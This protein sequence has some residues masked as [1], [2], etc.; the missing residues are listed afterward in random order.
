MAQPDG[1]R[2]ADRVAVARDMCRAG[3]GSRRIGRR[4]RPL[5]LQIGAVLPLPLRTR[6]TGDRVAQP[7]TGCPSSTARCPR[8]RCRSRPWRSRS[9][10]SAP[11]RREEKQTRQGR[12]SA[13]PLL[14]APRLRAFAVPGRTNPG[15]PPKGEGA[16]PHISFLATKGRNPVTRPGSSDECCCE[17]GRSSMGFPALAAPAR[18]LRQRRFPVRFWRTSRPADVVPRYRDHRGEAAWRSAGHRRDASPEAEA[19]RLHRVRERVFAGR[20]S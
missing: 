19:G 8:T 18:R 10:R 2:Y 20:L 11:P 14:T 3:G 6:T 1:E 15:R 13:Q 17:A 12:G 7:D 9:G 5:C 16:L 4:H